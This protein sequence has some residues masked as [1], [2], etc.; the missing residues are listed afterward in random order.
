ME[1]LE[2]VVLSDGSLLRGTER[3]GRMVDG[4]LEFSVNYSLHIYRQKE[5]KETMEDIEIRKG[6][7]K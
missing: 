4:I 5:T 7:V 2:Y 6:L 3:T 1:G